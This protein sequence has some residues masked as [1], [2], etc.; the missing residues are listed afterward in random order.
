MKY[1]V[2]KSSQG[3]DFMDWEKT[4]GGLNRLKRT[5]SIKGSAYVADKKT[6]EAVK[7]EVTEIS[8]E[9]Y[10][11]L[12]DNPTFKQME[13][14]GYMVVMEKEKEAKKEAEKGDKKDA[15][16]QLTPE[17]FEAAGKEPPV[18]DPA[19]TKSKRKRK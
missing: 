3:I 18:I 12:K 16:A 13:K 4:V 17:D 5:I 6:L 14:D 19:E 1:I 9:D 10:E 15:S 8:D 2:S 7:G 11:W